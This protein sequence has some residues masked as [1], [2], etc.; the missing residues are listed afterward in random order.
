MVVVTVLVEVPDGMDHQAFRNLVV[1]QLE[2]CLE[3]F[4][5]DDGPTFDVV[6]D[7][8]AGVAFESVPED[9]GAK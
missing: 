5:G 6:T 7:D 4:G 2:S 9:G 1:G 8:V 3:D